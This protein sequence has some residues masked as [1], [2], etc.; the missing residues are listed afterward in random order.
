HT[1]DP[2][3]IRTWIFPTNYAKR[4]YQFNIVQKAL[5][6]NILVALP[7]GLGK[8]LIAAV[9]M[10]NFY[11]WFPQGKVIFMAPTKPLVAQQIGACYEVCGIPPAETV[12]MTGSLPP[13]TRKSLWDSKRVF[14]LTPQVL[15][16]DIQRETCPS[17]DVVCLVVDEAH[18]AS[19]NHAYCEVV[20]EL[21]LRNPHFRILALT[22][23][24][25]QDNDIVQALINNLRISMI[26]LRTEQSA[27]IVKY[28]HGRTVDTVNVPF[29]DSLRRIR[30]DLARLITTYVAQLP[31]SGLPTDGTRVSPYQVQLART[32][33]RQRLSGP[34][35]IN[36]M[37]WAEALFAVVSNLSRAMQLL[38]YHGVRCG[39]ACLETA[40]TEAMEGPR[41]PSKTKREL[42]EGPMFRGL[43]T[44]MQEHLKD[45][46]RYSHPKLA[47][48][49]S[50]IL[51]HFS[52]D[53]IVASLPAGQ[54]TAASSPT[55]T[56]T[57]TRVMIFSQFRE[58]VEEIVSLLSHHSP[59]LRVM[60]FVGQS[61]GKTGKGLS[62][63]QQLEIIRQFK[64][65]NYNTLVATSIGEEG[66]DIGE[67]DLIICFDTQGSSI[68][69]L[70][71]MGRTGRKR[72][73]RI[74][75]LLAE[76]GEEALFKRSQ[77]TYQKVQEGIMSRK[78]DLAFCR[79]SPRMLPAP[80]I[81]EC[82]EQAL[83]I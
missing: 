62:Q 42:Y 13:K 79:D 70:Q 80:V 57:T 3:A 31:G 81:P 24:P 41:P 60:S 75:V 20:R 46:A 72:Q 19:G 5:A 34:A 4:D 50:I 23:T 54:S 76:D 21:T 71:R 14:F 25:G 45:P 47:R 30:S 38:S 35:Q 67:V 43:M 6:K 55:T 65:G 12:E 18:R 66:L 27:D 64:S 69:L 22:A 73:G 9:V 36:Q 44:Q 28:L 40:R 68:R 39:H 17:S 33:S 7:T 26:E 82:S 8:T 77:Q 10:Y 58:S 53:D 32:R 16:N 61:T 51:D 56:S 11:R 15:Q 1:Y 59:L 2:E 63:K 37:R 49:E 52:R 78:W 83:D 48:L 29:D 74:V